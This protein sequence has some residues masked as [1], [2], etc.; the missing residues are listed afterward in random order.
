M[1][2]ISLSLTLTLHLLFMATLV[3]LLVGYVS[4][5]R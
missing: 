1:S 4:F 2:V 3:G 5:S